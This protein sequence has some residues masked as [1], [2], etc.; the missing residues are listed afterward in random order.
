M[1]VQMEEKTKR[2]VVEEVIEIDP[3]TVER[4]PLQPRK[5]FDEEWI[6]KLAANMKKRGQRQPILVTVYAGSKP[7][8]EYRLIDGEN[9]VRAARLGGILVRAIVR[10]VAGVRQHYREA[11]GAN[12]F[13]QPHTP[14]EIAEVVREFHDV[15]KMTWEEIEDEL[16]MSRVTLREYYDLSRL[17]PTIQILVNRKE[18]SQKHRLPI[19][20]ASELSRLPPDEQRAM[21]DSGILRQ[22]SSDLAIQAIRKK[23]QQIEA[24]GGQVHRSKYGR[25]RRPS[26]NSD[27]AETHI[28]SGTERDYPCSGHAIRA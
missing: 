4:F 17:D 19:W 25:K 8:I 6:K 16:E 1:S 7:G 13:H 28:P 23:A 18:T 20:V 2:N 27:M 9:R 14:M 22:M 10:K 26:D 24:A 3:F 5:G 21:I 12:F 15:D 11:A